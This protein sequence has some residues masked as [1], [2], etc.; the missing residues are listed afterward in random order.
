MVGSLQ[1]LFGIV[2]DLCCYTNSIIV[3]R[4]LEV[5][6]ISGSELICCWCL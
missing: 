6:D 5:D 3:L 1:V 4:M 2:F